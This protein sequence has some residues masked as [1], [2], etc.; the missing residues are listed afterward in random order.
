MLKETLVIVIQLITGEEVTNR[1]PIDESIQ[2]SEV[3]ER[4]VEDMSIPGSRFHHITKG[5]QVRC[6]TDIIED[7]P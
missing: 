2:C 7:R 5:F 3:L 6:E 1:I 4:V